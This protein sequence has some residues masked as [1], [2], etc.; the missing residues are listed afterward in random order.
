VNL[1]QLYEKGATGV[2]KNI[3]KAYEMALLAYEMSN[4]DANAE[5]YGKKLAKD[6]DPAQ[7][8]KAKKSVEEK[9]AAFKNGT[10]AAAPA[11]APAPTAPASGGS[12]TKKKGGVK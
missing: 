6:L 8:E 7:I 5:A 9:L 2:E 4:K 3:N 10:A 1:A 12:S 11:P